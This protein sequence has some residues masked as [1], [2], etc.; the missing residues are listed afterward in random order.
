MKQ[1]LT[2]AYNTYLET[3]RDR[4]LYVFVAFA[5]AMI[6]ISIIM[7]SIS[8]NQDTK[9]IKDFG[10]AGMFFFGVLIA[11]FVG[12]NT[13]HKEK[14]K[15]TI[16][17]ILSK[18]IR[19]WQFILGK[20]LG[21]AL[22]LLVVT[23]LMSI[24]FLTITTIKEKSFSFLLLEA[25]FFQYLELILLISVVIAFS[26]FTSPLSAA[27]YTICLFI[28]GHSTTVINQIAAKSQNIFISKSLETVYYIFPNLEKFNLKTNVV[29]GIGYNGPETIIAILY[30]LFYIGL[31]LTL[32]TQILKKQ[33]F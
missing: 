32:A 4:I 21:L 23:L 16:Y 17:I 22:S 19:H 14:D 24:I 31:M 30:G 12:A 27:I 33:E 13:I 1:V 10:L 2:I 20:F 15:R 28:I 26:S 29:Y 18:P 8:L 25:I 3:I 5:I 6:G 9:I 7:G 11:V